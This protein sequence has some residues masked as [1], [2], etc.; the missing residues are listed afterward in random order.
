MLVRLQM[1][2]DRR[3]GEPGE[4]VREEGASPADWFSSHPD[5]EER[6]RRIL[7]RRQADRS[8]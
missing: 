2:M 3:I 7:G 5:T 1:Q 6:V 4:K 8:P